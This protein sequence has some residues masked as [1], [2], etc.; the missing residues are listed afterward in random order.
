MARLPR[1]DIEQIPQHIVQRGNNRSP[2]FIDDADRRRY[3]T[4]L[5]E[6]LLRYGCA[7]HAYVLMTN[8]VHLLATPAERGA[9]ARVMQMLGRLYVFAFNARHQRTGTL[10]EGRYKSCLVDSETYLLQCYRYVELNPV[11]S[12][13]VALPEEYSWSSYRANAS[14]A[15]DKLVTPHPVYL[16]LGM[17]VADRQTAYREL[18]M[19][20]LS[21]HQIGEIRAYLQQQRALGGAAFQ[22]RVE[23][24]LGRCARI[25]PA[26][27]PRS[28][29]DGGKAL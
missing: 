7:L 16:A 4:A 23:A 22:L 11:R 6:A 9:I 29:G 18:V 1:P 15:D 12:R 26:H 19:D 8:H 5:R 28:A 21:N 3:L 14:G 25:R 17:D 27:R 10:W 2:C 24:E 13:M 20:R